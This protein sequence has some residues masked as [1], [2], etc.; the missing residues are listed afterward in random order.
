MEARK[1][2]ALCGAEY[3]AGLENNA[4][5]A[6]TT[7]HAEKVCRKSMTSQPHLIKFIAT[8]I[9]LQELCEAN[10]MAVDKEVLLKVVRFCIIQEIHGLLHCVNAL[11]AAQWQAGQ[12]LELPRHA[13]LHHARYEARFVNA[14][15][16]TADPESCLGFNSE[17]P[18]ASNFDVCNGRG[19]PTR[20]L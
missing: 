9:L 16:T 15:G 10:D 18:P 20:Q 1:E 4:L 6:Q 2:P 19:W 5:Y 7:R 14:C 12:L 13:L 3:K 11:F 17:S 8:G